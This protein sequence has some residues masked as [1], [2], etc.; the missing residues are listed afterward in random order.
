MTGDQGID[1][2]VKAEVLQ[3]PDTK[4]ILPLDTRSPLKLSVW[5]MM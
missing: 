3:Q 2:I 4:N 1:L 5:E